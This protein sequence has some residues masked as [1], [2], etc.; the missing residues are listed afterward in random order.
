MPSKLVE[1]A[2]ATPSS[3]GL[4][5]QG[6]VLHALLIREMLTR[7]GRNNLGFLWLFLEPMLFTLAV[8]ALWTATRTIHGSDL[9]IT[10]FAITGYASMLMWRNMPARCI[11]AIKGNKSL[12][13]HRQ[14]RPLDVYL[15]R[16]LLE[17]GGSS[18]S[19]VL[20]V[21]AFWAFDAVALPEDALQL[22]GGWLT[23][24]WFGAGLAM[25][26]GALSEKSELVDK[27]WPP[28]SYLLFPFSG[29]AFI[30]E[31]LPEKAR[32]ILL[33]LPMLNCVEFIREGY[34]GTKMRAYYDMEYVVVF[35]LVL[36]LVA[37]AMV[38][39][40]TVEADYE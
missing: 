19:F 40:Q 7:Y 4:L 10:A 13:F 30:V 31:S 35:N 25:V 9:P 3:N 15:S 12:M 27:L 18:A 22:L 6:R 34:F 36:S 38:R 17:F 14:V 11:N 33:Y 8:T 1:P 16:I 5:V 29:A 24:G 23:L 37:L 39:L 20:L 2:Q 32:E 21:V 28:F 26:L